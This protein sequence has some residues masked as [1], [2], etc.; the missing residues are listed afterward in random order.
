MLV[1]NR[2]DSPCASRVY[3]Q[4]PF[5]FD[6]MYLIL[7]IQIAA[8]LCSTSVKVEFCFIKLGFVV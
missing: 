5:A 6:E 8:I 7:C 2:L 4:R 1:V 3:I